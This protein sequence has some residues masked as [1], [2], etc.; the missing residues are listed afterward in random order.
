MN[1]MFYIILL[2]IIVIMSKLI[3]KTKSKIIKSNTEKKKNK[4]I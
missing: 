1:K 4:F 3:F 2:T